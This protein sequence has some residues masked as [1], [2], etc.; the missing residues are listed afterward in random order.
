MIQEDGN[1]KVLEKATAASTS[2][3]LYHLIILIPTD[4]L[5]EPGRN[6]KRET[7]RDY[8]KPP[9]ECRSIQLDITF[10]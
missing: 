3:A 1:R 6:W 5:M 10:R 4:F 2:K 9:L 7:P 8:R